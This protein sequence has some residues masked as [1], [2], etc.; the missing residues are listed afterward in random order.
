MRCCHCG[1]DIKRSGEVWVADVG[2][3]EKADIIYS[4]SLTLDSYRYLAM[5]CNFTQFDSESKVHQP[6]ESDKVRLI[7]NKYEDRRS[8]N[9]C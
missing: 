4:N 7:L 6:D 2:L 8:R 9:R 3:A 5:W 1:R